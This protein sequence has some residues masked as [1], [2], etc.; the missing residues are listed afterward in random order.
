MGDAPCVKVSEDFFI[1]WIIYFLYSK[2]EFILSPATKL[3]VLGL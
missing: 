1:R 3:T 2:A